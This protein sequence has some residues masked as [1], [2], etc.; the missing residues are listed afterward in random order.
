VFDLKSALAKA[1]A[2]RAELEKKLAELKA[3]LEKAEAE[4]KTVKEKK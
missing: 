1:K 3:A 2:E 4:A